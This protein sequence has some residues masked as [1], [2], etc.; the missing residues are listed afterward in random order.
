M[1]C[2]IK[3]VS[4]NILNFNKKKFSCI[5]YFNMESEQATNKDSMLKIKPQKKINPSTL[6]I[7]K[8]YRKENIEFCNWK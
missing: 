5:F 4:L 3:F 7:Y 6:F 1:L 2:K 8:S